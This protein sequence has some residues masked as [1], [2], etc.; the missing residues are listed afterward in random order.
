MKK[1][2]LLLA[3]L[4]VA[5]ASMTA[6]SIITLQ[7][8]KLNSRARKENDINRVVLFLPSCNVGLITV[9]WSL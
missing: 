9:I 3:F 2:L 7:V 8:K 5:I 4:S 6:E 1:Y